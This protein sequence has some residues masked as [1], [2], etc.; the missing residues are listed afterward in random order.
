MNE[1][2]HQWHSDWSFEASSVDLNVM[3]TS[4]PQAPNSSTPPTLPFTYHQP[5]HFTSPSK[6]TSAGNST[7]AWAHALQLHSTLSP[8][9]SPLP[10]T[11]PAFAKVK[12]VSWKRLNIAGLLVT[13][14]GLQELP[15]N[16]DEV[17]CL[18]LLHGRGDTQDSMAFTAAGFLGK[19]SIVA[20][21][22]PTFSFF[23]VLT[24]WTVS[25]NISIRNIVS[26]PSLPTAL[27]SIRAADAFSTN[28]LILRSFA[29]W[30][31]PDVFRL[32][33][34]TP[35]SLS[36]KYWLTPKPGNLAS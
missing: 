17:P 34:Q 23:G 33:S 18:W 6:M 24:N 20:I 26:R 2:F 4:L 8:F 30:A 5:L 14:Y 16:V 3:E 19:T 27:L 9:D 22:V 1:M 11:H 12:P 29:G 36:R 32:P 21:N 13:I 10:T 7:F 28:S 25:P 35:R 15:Q 31:S